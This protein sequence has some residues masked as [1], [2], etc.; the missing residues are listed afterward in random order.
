MLNNSQ[1]K[2]IVDI[3][4]KCKNIAVV[5]LSPNQNKPSYEVSKY[6]QERGYEI[7]PVYP[8]KCVI[9]GKESVSSIRKINENVDLVLMFRKGEFATELIDDISAKGIKNFWLQLGITN[10][11]VRLLCEELGI[12]FVQDACIKIEINKMEIDKQTA[13]Q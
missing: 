13:N 10:D 5:G 11:N 1:S 2:T 6:L 9:L 7:F 4:K 12:N 3:I 8:K